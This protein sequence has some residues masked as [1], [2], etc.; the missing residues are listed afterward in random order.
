MAYTQCA[1]V[2][3]AALA[4]LAGG[5]DDAA[6]PAAPRI[7]QPPVRGDVELGPT[8]DRIDL[9]LPTFSDPTTVDNPLNP[10][11]EI[12]SA[13][14]LGRVDG[15][16]LRIEITLLPETR[17]IEWE[18]RSVETLVS[19]FVAYRGGRILEVAVDLY[20]Q[21]DDGAVWYFGE[22]VFNYADDG[23]IADM[24][25]AWLAGRDGPAGM[26]TPADPQVGDVYRSEN[27]PGLVF[28]ES[29]VLSVDDTVE[30]P[31]GP[32]DGA[33]TIDEHHYPGGAEEKTFAPGYGE[34]FTGAGGDFEQTALAVP[35][36]A[37]PGPPPVRLAEI[38]AGAAGIYDA[39]A[40][41]R[42]PALR[43]RIE[44]VR[45]DWDAYA[46]VEPPRLLAGQMNRAV[47]QLERAAREGG[48]L[49]ARR[50]AVE[51]AVAALD[52]ELRHRPP[53]VIDRARFDLQLAELE[54]DAAAR[55]ADAVRADA[56]NLDW[57]RDRIVAGLDEGV[58]QQ[59]DADLLRLIAA[60]SEEDY[61]AA[62][63]AAARLRA[64]TRS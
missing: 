22:D 36:D 53:A 58:R 48:R 60:G 63:A 7:P 14:V 31:R 18:G 55:D 4:L 64:L 32:V 61:A 49:A 29:T 40:S 20:A 21:A 51:V 62:G 23:H 15:E 24:E 34:F 30:G 50:A 19:Q 1:L 59:L 5:C 26:I 27:V 56:A 3:G 6:T 10:L 33:Y 8:A 25:G 57:L 44:R 9:E 52:L 11:S 38:A 41:A 28:E 43:S 47:A 35:I 2:L 39:E 46:R 16:P 13:L 12:P 37:L 17:T 54:I 42:M 45:A